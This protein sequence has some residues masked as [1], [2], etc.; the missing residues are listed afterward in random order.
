[1]F[2]LFK[3]CFSTLEVSFPADIDKFSVCLASNDTPARQHFKVFDMDMYWS[4]EKSEAFEELIGSDIGGI[5]I[6]PQK[7]DISVDRGYIEVERG[8]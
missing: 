4:I 7:S 5:A 1:M 3:P 2:V 6:I 8:F